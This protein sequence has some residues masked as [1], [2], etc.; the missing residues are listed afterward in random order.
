[1]RDALLPLHQITLPERL[2]RVSFD[3]DELNDL[4]Q[5]I[6]ANG[7]INAVSVMQTAEAYELIAGHRRLIA[8][9][10]IGQTHIQA[11]IYEPA[12]AYNPDAVRF[13]ENLHRADLSPMEEGRAIRAYL[14]AS[15]LSLDAIARLLHRSLDWCQH[16]LTLLELPDELAEVLHTKRLGV[17]QALTLHQVTEPEHR[18]YLLRYA[19]DAGATVQT[20]REW[21]AHWKLAHAAGDGANAPRPELPNPGEPVVILVP[22]YICASPLPYQQMRILR[23]CPD[24]ARHIAG[25]GVEASLPAGGTTDPT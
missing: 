12:D 21:V 7:L 5:S 14:D 20:L 19:L 4:M 2:H 9:Q 13:H 23:A 16:R 17:A 25:A 11:R 18:N 6:R 10:R 24:C 1:M 3:E 8:H 15:A 22:C